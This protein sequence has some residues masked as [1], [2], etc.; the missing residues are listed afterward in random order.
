MIKEVIWCDSKDL[1][2]PSPTLSNW[3]PFWLDMLKAWLEICPVWLDIFQLNLPCLELELICSKLDLTHPLFDLM[4]FQL[5]LK[6]SWLDLFLKSFSPNIK[7]WIIQGWYPNELSL[8]IIFLFYPSKSKGKY[9]S[10]YEKIRAN[11][12]LHFWY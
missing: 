3:F 10:K 11:I 8:L 2:L 12:C 7:D 9:E 6:C 1:P 5:D 4:C